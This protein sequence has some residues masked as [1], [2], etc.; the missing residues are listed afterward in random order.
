MAS[1]LLDGIRIH[2]SPEG[3][4]DFHGPPVLLIHGLGSSGEDWI[5]QGDVL[6]GRR[7]IA[8]VDLPGF[9]K[10]DGFSFVPHLEDYARAAA[11][12][13]REVWGRPVH[14]VGLSLG[15][16]V[17][18]EMAAQ[19][20]ESVASVVAVGTPSGLSLGLGALFL[21][22]PLLTSVLL[23]K[24]NWVGWLVARDL[25]PQADQKMIR[26]EAQQLLANNRRGDYLRALAALGRSRLRK[27]V[28][29]L[30]CPVLIVAGAQDRTVRVGEQRKL[31]SQIRGARYAEVAGSRHATPVDSPEVFNRL[32]LSFLDEVESRASG[33]TGLQGA[34]A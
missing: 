3:P 13:C 2:Y 31:A 9:G 27:H 14:V 33:P 19:D 7:A 29:R 21:G 5:F 20:A 25:F 23:G 6:A 16:A 28:A 4:A 1:L 11:G 24:M 18:L 32:L 22:F 12:L 17:G 30:E 26:L 34:A 15:G 8:T 10:S